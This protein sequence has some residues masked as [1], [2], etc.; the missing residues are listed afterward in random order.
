ME[1]SKRM[2]L[3]STEHI[4]RAV[5]GPQKVYRSNT[6]YRIEGDYKILNP[7]TDEIVSVGGAGVDLDNVYNSIKRK[8]RWGM[9]L[10][11]LSLILNIIILKN[12]ISKR[13]NK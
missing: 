9:V 1:L 3:K 13:R 11:A 4:T 12:I 10:N 6:L 8:N 7:F 5:E 2:G